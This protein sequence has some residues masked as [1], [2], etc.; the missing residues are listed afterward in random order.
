MFGVSPDPYGTA[1]KMGGDESVDMT[2][3]AIS[4]SSQVHYEPIQTDQ[5]RQRRSKK[6]S[7]I[8]TNRKSTATA[9]PHGDASM[10]SLDMKSTGRKLK[11]IR[12][13]KG[14]EDSSTSQ[15]ESDIMQ[16]K[17]DN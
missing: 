15:N 12:K 14:N 7:L 2:N 9:V 3:G 11:R 17:Q 10:S 5:K 6:E 1:R 16:F 4:S 8:D 13:K